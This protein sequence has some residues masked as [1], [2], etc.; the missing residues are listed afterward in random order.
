[1]STGGVWFA[2]NGE[3]NGS[4][5]CP[6]PPRLSLDVA[7][8][9]CCLPAARMPVEASSSRGCVK[10]FSDVDAI[11]REGLMGGFS[12]LRVVV[13]GLRRAYSGMRRERCSDVSIVFINV[14]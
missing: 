6:K 2:R 11:F 10:P 14:F 4:G 9:K 12:F 7:S 13:T 3:D 1:M 5:A 8:L